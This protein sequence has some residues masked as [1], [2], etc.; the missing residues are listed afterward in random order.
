MIM[1][2]IKKEINELTDRLIAY[3]VKYYNEDAP[4]ISDFEYDSLMNHL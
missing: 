1:D 4:E 3:A 2:D